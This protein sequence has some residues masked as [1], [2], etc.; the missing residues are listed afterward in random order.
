MGEAKKERR[1]PQFLHWSL[2]FF[3]GP[4]LEL[5]ARAHC[6]A[7]LQ[8]VWARMQVGAVSKAPDGQQGGEPPACGVMPAWA[9]W[10]WEGWERP[11]EMGCLFV[12]HR[13]APPMSETAAQT[14]LPET[15]ALPAEPRAPRTCTRW[16]DWRHI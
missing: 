14:G 6:P 4:P 3:Q 9:R 1:S 8:L 15:G 2:P 7:G 12:P 11:S 5:V 13:A 10:G 16:A